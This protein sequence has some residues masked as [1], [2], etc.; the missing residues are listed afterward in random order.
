[1]TT[2]ALAST[3]TLVASLAAC[4][5][6]DGGLAQGRT[7]RPASDAG[8]EC[9]PGGGDCP[10]G[11][12]C[13]D[14]RCAPVD[15]DADGDGVPGVIDCA[16]ADPAIGREAERRC[17]SE[18]AA[19][20]E[21]CID[22]VW[23][24]CSAPDVCECAP[25]GSVR[26]L[27]CER[28]GEREQ[29]CGDTLTWQP[30]GECLRQGPCAPEEIGREEM[31]CGNCCSGSMSRTRTCGDTCEWGAYGPWSVCAG[32]TGCEP[33]T[34]EFDMRV[35]GRCDSGTQ[36]RTRTCLPGSCTFSEWE[37]WGV[38]EGEVGCVPAEARV[39][40]SAC[41]AGPTGE[42]VCGVRTRTSVCDSSCAWGPPGPWGACEISMACTPGQVDTET[43]SCGVCTGARQ[44]TRTC[45][46]TCGWGPTGPWSA[47]TGD[48]VCRLPWG[49]DVCP[50]WHGRWT[51]CCPDGRL[52]E[53]G[54][55]G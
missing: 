28:C 35:C 12:T 19:G 47:C 53:I 20:L 37:A 41:E 15:D 42:P 10:F 32:A 6:D 38:C 1:M 36:R 30:P 43:E 51:E 18:C 39:E 22:G 11:Q 55:C 13:V 16:P 7:L 44:R 17:E 25:T 52:R 2:R 48:V 8:P 4:Q 26:R 21:A 45:D 40:T 31:P 46:A 34:V 9:V 54:D 27:E 24:E 23:G 29:R 14:G 33:D 5:I 50:G 49:W 3:L